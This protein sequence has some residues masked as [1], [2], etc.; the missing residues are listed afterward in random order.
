MTENDQIEVA[1]KAQILLSWN[2]DLLAVEVTINGIR[3]LD[4][5]LMMLEGAKVQLGFQRNMIAVQQME[6]QQAEIRQAGQIH[7]CIQR[8]GGII[9]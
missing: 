7:N 1:P 9:R 5:A 3:N 2:P 6:A 8:N 4:F